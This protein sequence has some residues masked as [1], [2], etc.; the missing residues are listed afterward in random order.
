MLYRTVLTVFLFGVRGFATGFFQAIYLYTP[1]VRMLLT[2]LLRICEV[3]NC[4]CIVQVYPTSVRGFGMS[5]CSSFSC[6]GAM[7]AP[8]IAQV[9]TSV[10]TFP[11]IFTIIN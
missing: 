3:N 2:V 10:S 6:I 11:L 7:L 4:P 9:C 5:L 1:E 8:Y